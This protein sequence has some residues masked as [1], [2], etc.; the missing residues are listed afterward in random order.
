[1]SDVR[2]WVA[3]NQAFGYTSHRQADGKF[4]A[5]K[6]RYDKTK[7]GTA[8]KKR[9]FGRRKKARETA[10][11]WYSK[12]RTV[13]K[14]E[15]TKKEL[16]Q[17]KIE[18]CKAHIRRHTTRLKLLKTLIKKWEKRKKYYERQLQAVR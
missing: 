6:Y 13:K 18:K 9:A 14:P 12:R 11:N 17:R 1:M 2:Y 7:H 10:Y 5:I 15:P 8:I 16:I 4:Y 3:G